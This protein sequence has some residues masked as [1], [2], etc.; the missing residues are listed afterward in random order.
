MPR[1]CGRKN[2]KYDVA[3]LLSP[4]QS[5]IF[6]PWILPTITL[7]EAT[8]K[9]PSSPKFN[10]FPTRHEQRNMRLD[11]MMMNINRGHSLRTTACPRHIIFNVNRKSKLSIPQ[12]RASSFPLVRFDLGIFTRSAT[13]ALDEVNAILVYCVHAEGCV[14]ARALS[15]VV[16]PVYLEMCSIRGKSADVLP[17]PRANWRPTFPP[18]PSVRV[19]AGVQIIG[20]LGTGMNVVIDFL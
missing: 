14:R 13:D 11:A 10:G 3:S 1:G 4:L 9:S 19:S 8:R 12:V 6:L 7:L 5:S 16:L 20:G 15:V 2:P 18:L 17:G